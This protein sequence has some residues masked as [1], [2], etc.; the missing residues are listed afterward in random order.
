[1]GIVK[2]YH[3]VMIVL[4]NEPVLVHEPLSFLC[5]FAPRAIVTKRRSGYDRLVVTDLNRS[6]PLCSLP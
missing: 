4:I 2:T 3:D 6:T 5:S 1:M